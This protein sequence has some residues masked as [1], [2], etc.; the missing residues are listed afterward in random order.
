MAAAMV[1]CSWSATVMVRA[2]LFNQTSVRRVG[3]GVGEQRF[4]SG[5]GVRSVAETAR[6]KID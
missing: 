5:I 4:Q 2:L 6:Y 1:R 3:S